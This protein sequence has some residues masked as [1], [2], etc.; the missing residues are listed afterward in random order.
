MNTLYMKIDGEMMTKE[1]RSEVAN[2]LV[3]I[4]KHNAMGWMSCQSDYSFHH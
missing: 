2:I 4:Y 3:A 1:Q